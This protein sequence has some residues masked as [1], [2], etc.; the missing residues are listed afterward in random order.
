MMTTRN[1]GPNTDRT[2]AAC[3]RAEASDVLAGQVAHKAGSTRP[4]AKNRLDGW[5]MQE[6]IPSVV[7]TYGSGRRPAHPQLPSIRDPKAEK[8]WKPKNAGRRGQGRG[9]LS[10]CLVVAASRC[11]R[12]PCWEL[13][14]QEEKSVRGAGTGILNCSYSVHTYRE[15]AQGFV[16][17]RGINRSA[18]SY[19]WPSVKPS[20]SVSP[21]GRE[22]ICCVGM[23]WDSWDDERKARL[24][25]PVFVFKL[26]VNDSHLCVFQCCVSR[27]R[28]VWHWYLSTVDKSRV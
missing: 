17:G 15:R 27:R 4:P 19:S 10:C 5:Q 21:R 13:R 25:L 26:L 9:Q 23:K 3:S 28:L 20:Q 24:F 22:R 12:E 7:Q 6:H 18:V 1:W 14:K 16:A 11:G 8:R 2:C